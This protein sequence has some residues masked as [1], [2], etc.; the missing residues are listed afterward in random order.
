MPLAY[1]TV[2]S[3]DQTPLIFLHGLGASSRQTTSALTG[4][5]DHFVI[6]PDLPG[7]GDSLDYDPA[8]FGFDYFADQV[9]AL[10]DALDLASVDLGGLSMGSGITLNLALRYPERVKKLILLRP[11]WLDQLEPAH[12]S[13]VARVGQWLHEQGEEKAT[14]QLAF[15]PD[16]QELV[17]KNMPVAESLTALLDRP[18][19]AAST[20][21][22][23]KMWQSRPFADLAELSRLTQPALVL[24]TTRDELHPQEVSRAIAGALP[25]SRLETLPPRYH[26]GPAYQ[27]AL[28]EQLRKFLPAS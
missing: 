4:L 19:D 13:L 24:D 22:L 25:N 20:Q 2:G 16:Y 23:F 14:A 11:S 10:M 6:A 7:H 5:P 28:N 21:V 3:P 1:A 18:K 27:Q 12:L 9:I 15:H 17:E 26:D 8:Q